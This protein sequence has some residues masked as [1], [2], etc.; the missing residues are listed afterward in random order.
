[1]TCFRQLKVLFVIVTND[2]FSHVKQ[3]AKW[4]FLLMNYYLVSLYV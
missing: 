4:G 2:T 1:M 3:V